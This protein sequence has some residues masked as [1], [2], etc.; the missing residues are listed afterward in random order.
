M[1]RTD[2]LSEAA[3]ATPHQCSALFP[4]FRADALLFPVAQSRPGNPQ[5]SARNGVDDET[6]VASTQQIAQDLSEF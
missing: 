4:Q 5:V 6:I 1:R 3:I 2:F